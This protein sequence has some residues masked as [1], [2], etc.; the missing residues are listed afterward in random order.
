M[1]ARNSII[2]WR[3]YTLFEAQLHA[4]PFRISKK[5]QQL[6]VY[7]YEVIPPTNNLFLG[8]VLV[9]TS[10]STSEESSLLALER[11]NLDEEVSSLSLAESKKSLFCFLLFAFRTGDESEVTVKVS[12]V[13]VREFDGAVTS[14]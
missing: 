11:G 5:F 4:S 10:A 3:Y 13:S 8:I 14:A 9:S 6:F 1:K 12:V 2:P 7:G